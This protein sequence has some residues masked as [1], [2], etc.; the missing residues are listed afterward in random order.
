[1]TTIT[2]LNEK[3]AIFEKQ[4]N[5]LAKELKKDLKSVLKEIFKTVPSIKSIYWTQYT[6]YF[7]DGDTCEFSIYEIIVSNS[8]DEFVHYAGDDEFEDDSLWAENA[9]S[10][11]H[12]YVPDA[13]QRKL[14]KDF[15]DM[16]FN[17]QDFL[18]EIFGDHV[19][20]IG[21]KSGFKTEEYEHD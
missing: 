18:Q 9:D 12:K 5:D 20:V 17:S 14:L 6:P 2:E 4:K 8:K 11:S 10:V 16:I 13:E 1:M 15:S 19:R 3:L 21:T 7:M